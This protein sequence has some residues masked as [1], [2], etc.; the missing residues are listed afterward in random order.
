MYRQNLTESLHFSH[1]LSFLQKN[2]ESANSIYKTQGAGGGGCTL[3][4]ARE[5]SSGEED[6][7]L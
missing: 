7:F 6:L 4:T 3:Q 5:D 2:F 1:H